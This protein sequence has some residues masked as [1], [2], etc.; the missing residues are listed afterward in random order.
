M[1]MYT[2]FK[3]TKLN[4]ATKQ[5]AI[6]ALLIEIFGLLSHTTNKTTGKK[7][8]WVGKVRDA[9]HDSTE[10]WQLADLAKLADVH[11]VHLS[12]TFSKYFHATL[13]D[14]I[15]TVKIQQALSLLPDKEISLTD[16]AIQCGFA[17]QSHFIR[18]FKSYQQLTPLRYRKLLLKK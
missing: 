12:R 15:R 17:D 18:S 7:P 6:D 2:I 8:G 3:E 14:Y 16:I 13:G 11:P 5:L 4:Q 9:L 1:L 10:N